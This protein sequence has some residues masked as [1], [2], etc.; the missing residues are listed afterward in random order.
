MNHPSEDS[1]IQ[2]V[3]QTLGESDYAETQ[4]HISRCEQCRARARKLQEEVGRI[5]SVKI[6]VDVPRAPRLP[7]VPRAYIRRWGWV[8]GLAAGFL[9]GLLTTHFGEERHPNA[10]PQRLVT[11][12]ALNSSSGYVSCQAMD[13]RTVLTP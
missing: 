6:Q 13:V 10:V 4:E 11:T 1:L 2:L 12:A 9:L 5:G 7:G 8:A 3:L